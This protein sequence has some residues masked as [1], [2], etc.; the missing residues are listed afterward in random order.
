MPVFSNTS[1]ILGL[2]AIDCLHLLREQFERLDILP[3]EF[4]ELKTFTNFRG[5]D[6]II[7]ALKEGWISQVKVQYLSLVRAL[8]LE[9]DQ[10][11]AGAIA[12]ALQLGC[13]RILMDESDGRARAKILGINP[14][15]VCEFC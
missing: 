1:P 14:V 5:V 10:G 7:R 3:A 11:E 9:L 12:L 6:E 15:G 4:S 2:A 13:S 8:S